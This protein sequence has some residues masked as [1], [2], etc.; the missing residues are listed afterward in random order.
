MRK[1]LPVLLAGL[2]LFSCG[3]HEKSVKLDKESSIYQLAQELSQKV[4][5]L[6]PEKNTALIT[7][8]HFD[9]TI[10]D[11]FSTFQLMYGDGVQQLK[12][13]EAEQ[14]TEI[15]KDNAKAL[16]E[17]KL[18]LQAAKKAKISI[19]DAEV[20]SV[21]DLQY[22][23]VG[24]KEKFLNYLSN[25]NIN[26]KTLREDVRENLAI[27]KI[28]EKTLLDSSVITED[29][30]QKYYNEVDKTASVRHILMV[31]QGKSPE[32]K[33]EI[34]TKMQ[35]V[36][37]KARKGE[38]FESL[39]KKYSQDPGSKDNGGLYK[40]F[41]RGDMVK[42]FEDAAFNLPIGS[43]SD[44]VETPYGYH[45]IKVIDRKKE[46][47]P[48]DSVRTEIETTLKAQRQDDLLTNLLDRLK[49]DNEYKEVMP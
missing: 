45:I 13:I 42:A 34:Q 21:L 39:A 1:L 18:L 31:T 35:E 47:R 33:A 24:G 3:K 5:L 26:F 29:E 36:L 20:D 2:F 9:V 48:L 32:E 25:A 11:V 23:Q 17:K 4:P 43:I 15:F 46:T 14:L 22:A 41:S 49:A 38:N 28:I 12:N 10:G 16:A 44:I 6:D 40:D 37:D 19:S 8:K 30:I 27:N 7:T